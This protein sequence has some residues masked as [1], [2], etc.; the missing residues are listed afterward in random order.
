[1]DGSIGPLSAADEGFCHQIADT[2]AV[3]GQSD[4]SWTEKVCAMAAARDGSLQI[5]FGLGKYANRNVMDGYGGISRG[6]EQITVRSSRRLSPQP[7]RTI[8]GPL[9]YEVVKPLHEVRFALEANSCQPIAFDFTFTSIVPPALEPRTH[10]RTGYRISGD[11]V[12]YHQTGVAAGWVEVDGDRTEITPET[13]VS[14][15]DHSWGL[16]Y[17]VGQP[18]GDLE[19]TEDLSGVAF[20]FLWSPVYMEKPDGTQYALFINY[21]MF[22]AA[23]VRSTEV[24]S[25]IEHP[26]GL[27]DRIVDVEP[28]LRYD[29]DNRR[30][31]GG[32]L[33]CTMADGSA[34]PLEITAV[35]DTGFHLGAGL[36]FGFDGHHHGEWRGKRFVEGERIDDCSTPENARRLHQLRDT[37]IHVVDP[38]GGGEGWGNCQPIITGG[39]A[40]L[41][42]SP[43]SS[44]I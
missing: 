19:P 34:R 39:D 1:M 40:A 14:T 33:N 18:V 25:S 10:Q 3:V 5:G 22:D 15:R 29:P 8:V 17:D 35:S 31:L 7:D 44:F 13:W 11:L 32:T 42:L 24:A 12:R 20:R 6:V 38:V 43:E 23:G 21:R 41:G 4:L 30:L 37:V 9:Q 28:D 36:Y 2:F 26:S 16:R 27:T